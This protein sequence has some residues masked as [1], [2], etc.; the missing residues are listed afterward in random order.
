MKR[1]GCL[2]GLFL[3]AATVVVALWVWRQPSELESKHATIWPEM[4][5]DEVEKIMPHPGSAI[6]PTEPYDKEG[7]VP[8][9]DHL[10]QWKEVTLK[11]PPDYFLDLRA[12]FNA[13]GR[14]TRT[15]VNGRQLR[16]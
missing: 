7:F 16:P 4:T 8:G 6:R 2:A 13:N 12:Y 5:E 11:P 15:T 3:L 9:E 14:V 1:W 10:L